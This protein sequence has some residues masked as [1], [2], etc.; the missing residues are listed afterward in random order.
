MVTV[1]YEW[2]GVVMGSYVVETGG[3]RWLQVVIDDSGWLWMVR[4][5]L[6]VVMGW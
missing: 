4:G 2:L 1:G 6:R 5:L 3:Y